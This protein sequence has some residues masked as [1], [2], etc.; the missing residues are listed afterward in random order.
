[1]L[2]LINSRDEERE[3]LETA[4]QEAASPGVRQEILEAGCGRHW[5][6]KLERVEYHLTGIDFDQ[7][8]IEIRQSKF[9]D[10]RP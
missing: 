8:A 6:L 7:Q 10:L 5:P 2:K 3:I 9:N 1:M 4:I